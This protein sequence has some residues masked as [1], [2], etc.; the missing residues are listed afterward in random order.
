MYIVKITGCLS[1]KH[2]VQ[3]TQDLQAIDRRT[4]Y[5]H[6]HT[7]HCISMEVIRTQDV[8]TTLSVCVN[9]ATTNHE[10]LR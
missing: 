9:T 1:G 2:R 4:T 10:Y 6:L 8:M 7:C 3:S 5:G